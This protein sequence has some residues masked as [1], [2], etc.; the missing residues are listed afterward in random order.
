MQEYSV[1]AGVPQGFILGPSP[2]LLYINDLDHAI[3]DIGIHANNTTRYT[4]CD[5]GSNMCQQ[6]E[7]ASELK[8]DLRDTHNWGRKWLV[9]SMLEKLDMFCL[10]DPITGAIEVKTDWPLLGEK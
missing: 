3:F 9:I 6:L 8:Y 1:N 4:K 5:K 10:T 2:F 7:L